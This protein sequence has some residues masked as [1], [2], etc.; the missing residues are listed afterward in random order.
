MTVDEKSWNVLQMFSKGVK[1]TVET[2]EIA[3]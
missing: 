3:H 2:E 1:N